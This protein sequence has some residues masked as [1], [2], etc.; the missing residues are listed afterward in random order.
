MQTIV[1]EESDVQEGKAPTLQITPTNQSQ[2][3]DQL[4]ESSRRGQGNRPKTEFYGQNIMANRTSNQNENDEES[5]T[6]D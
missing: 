2:Q 4:T 6:Q 5:Q 1:E 3:K